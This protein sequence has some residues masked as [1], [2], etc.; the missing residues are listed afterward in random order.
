MPF[1]PPGHPVPEIRRPRR[2]CEHCGPVLNGF[3]VVGD[4]MADIWL[5]CRG[6]DWGRTVDAGPLLAVVDAAVEH[7]PHCP[8][9]A[10]RLVGDHG[11]K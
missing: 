5:A 6:C 1:L 9:D 7:V 3:T 4:G 11:P 8:H 2:S 10:Y